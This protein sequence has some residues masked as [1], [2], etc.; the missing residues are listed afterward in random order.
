MGKVSMEKCPWLLPGQWGSVPDLFPSQGPD[1]WLVEK[2]K[3]FHG[4]TAW[5]CALGGF[6]C[7][8]HLSRVTRFLSWIYNLL[9]VLKQ[10]SLAFHIYGQ[11]GTMKQLFKELYLL[12][13]VN[14]I[15]KCPAEISV[16]TQTAHILYYLYVRV[17]GS[18]QLVS[19]WCINSPYVTTLSGWRNLQRWTDSCWRA[20]PKMLLREKKCIF[21][22]LLDEQG[23]KKKSL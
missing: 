18:L 15:L 6:H 3:C 10:M 8:T 5:F 17:C 11:L 22:V 7:S 1:R 4:C 19:V 23:E 2:W 20:T 21:S 14:K 9:A 13:D 12:L 16:L